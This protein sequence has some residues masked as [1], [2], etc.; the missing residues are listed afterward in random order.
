MGVQ[1]Y[2][3]IQAEVGTAA[4]VAE[5]M[6]RLPG[7][8]AADDVIGPYDVIVRCEAETVD[9]LGRLVAGRMQMVPGVTRTTTCMV[10]N[11]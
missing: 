9:E 6:R 5:A 8:L 11:L 4:P 10:V 1:G 7:V 3:L 2:I